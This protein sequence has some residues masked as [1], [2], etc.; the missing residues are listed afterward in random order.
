M[1]RLSCTIIVNGKLVLLAAKCT[2]LRPHA[3]QRHP[4]F[5][6]TLQAL[7]ALHLICYSLPAKALSS[8]FETVIPRLDQLSH[9]Q[10]LDLLTAILDSGE[11]TPKPM[12]ARFMAAFTRSVSSSAAGGLRSAPSEL[13]F[14]VVGTAARWRVPLDQGWLGELEQEL[15]GRMA[16]QGGVP[17]AGALAA[18]AVDGSGA[19][20]VSGGPA[21]G[22]AGHRAAG[23]AGREVL[24]RQLLGSV[25]IPVAKLGQTLRKVRAVA[26]CTRMR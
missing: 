19:A 9:R 15:V 22:A 14:A 18:A 6:P 23:G 21:Q 17:G 5:C 13:L 20:V 25:I 7:A 11:Q 8:V 3:N 26:T 10:Q 16:G 12:A 4:W 2:R 24:T 1:L